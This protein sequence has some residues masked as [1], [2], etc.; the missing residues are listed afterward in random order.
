[1]KY[2]CKFGAT[3]RIIL[4]RIFILALKLQLLLWIRFCNFGANKINK[5]KRINNNNNIYMN[6]C[7][8]C[9]FCWLVCFC[10][11][12]AYV[13]LVFCFGFVGFC[14]FVIFVLFCMVVAYVFVMFC[15]K[16]QQK[17]THIR[18]T[19]TTTSAFAF[20]SGVVLKTG[21][22]CCFLVWL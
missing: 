21:L 19:L 20:L 11:V 7:C 5:N 6:V 16:Q 1:M 18:I 8:C 15:W 12:V 17:T 2:L 3:K 9:W 22:S 14:C 13:W 10:M 4:I